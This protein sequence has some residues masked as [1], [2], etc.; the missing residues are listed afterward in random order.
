[1]DW[2]QMIDTLEVIKGMPLILVV[3]VVYILGYLLKNFTRLD[4]KLI[5]WFLV[6]GGIL[7]N[8]FLSGF[9]L[10]NGIIGLI[11]AYVVMAFYE[12]IKNTIEYVI[13]HK[14]KE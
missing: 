11:I 6:L 5:P 8:L 7:V 14:R 1:M 9:T 3:A 4:N 10:P 12:H 13:T 2:K